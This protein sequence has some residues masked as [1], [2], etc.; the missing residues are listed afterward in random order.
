M[1]LAAGRAGRR[2]EIKALRRGAG[3]NREGLR[4][5]AT[6]E[7]GE[8]GLPPQ[9]FRLGSCF[10][11]PTRSFV[12]WRKSAAVSSA[13]V[14]AREKPGSAGAPRCEPPPASWVGDRKGS[15]PAEQEVAGRRYKQYST[16]G[17]G[18]VTAL[19]SATFSAGEVAGRRRSHDCA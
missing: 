19:Q 14:R 6:A 13:L 17:L 11:Q 15:S 10:L 3:R 9:S 5:G 18:P 8:L 16:S 1:L 4:D 12:W 7:L 2:R